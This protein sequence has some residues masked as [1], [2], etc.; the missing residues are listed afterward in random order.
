[1]HCTY[2]Y[3]FLNCSVQFSIFSLDFH[4]PFLPMALVNT[5]CTPRLLDIYL[6]SLLYFLELLALNQQK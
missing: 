6:N 1:M 3:G 4:G 2:Y 5:L